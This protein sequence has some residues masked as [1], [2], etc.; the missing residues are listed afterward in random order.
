[1]CEIYNYIKKL[2]RKIKPRTYNKLH[3]IDIYYNTKEQE[4]VN[5]HLIYTDPILN[6]T[7]TKRG[8][9]AIHRIFNY[10]KQPIIIKNV[11]IDKYKL[12]IIRY[13]IYTSNAA[14]HEVELGE[15]LR[16]VINDNN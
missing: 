3:Y 16:N 1:M 12:L 8:A 6:D 14:I 10:D 5:I 7:T 2:K 9:Q 13:D 15:N 11:D 4:P